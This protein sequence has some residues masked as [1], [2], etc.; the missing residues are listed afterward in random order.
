MTLQAALEAQG[1][2]I[3]E[4]SSSKYPYIKMKFKE[5]KDFVMGYFFRVNKQYYQPFSETFVVGSSNIY[6][7]TAYDYIT[8]Q[9][10]DYTTL[11]ELLY[12]FVMYSST[13]DQFEPATR[14]DMKDIY[15]QKVG[16]KYE[17]AYTLYQL[18]YDKPYPIYIYE[19]ESLTQTEFIPDNTKYQV[20]LI[21]TTWID[22]DKGLYTSETIDD[23][24]NI[25]A[26]IKSEHDGVVVKD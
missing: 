23:I 7:Q 26:T 12:G 13:A 22:K 10:I 24:Y 11:P 15:Y 21:K 25:T 19:T 8:N 6:T 4:V 5:D 14:F 18:L 17:R 9:V 20:K 1:F 2:T 3:T 16:E